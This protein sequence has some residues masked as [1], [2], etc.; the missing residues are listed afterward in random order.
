MDHRA[1][2][3]LAQA[4]AITDALPEIRIFFDDLKREG[5]I[6]GGRGE[7]ARYIVRLLEGAAG[8]LLLRIPEDVA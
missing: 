3:D 7:T 8:R 4:Q 5:S 6:W 2:S 1:Q